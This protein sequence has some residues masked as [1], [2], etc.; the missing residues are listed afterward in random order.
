MAMDLA[1]KVVIDKSPERPVE[2]LAA[3]AAKASEAQK[4]QGRNGHGSKAWLAPRNI[5]I[6]TEID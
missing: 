5:S 4:R 1:A 2:E 3:E 6:P